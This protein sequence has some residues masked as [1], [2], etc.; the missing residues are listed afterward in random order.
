MEKKESSSKIL[1]NYNKNDYTSILGL[2]KYIHADAYKMIQSE[3]WTGT[4][5]GTFEF[6]FP[7]Y[8]KESTTFNEGVL[9]S[10]VLH[11]ESNWLDLSSQAGLLS[12]LIVLIVILSLLFLTL[13]KN[14]RSRS[15]LLCLSCILSIFCILFH[16]IVD[17]PG[18]K[19]GIILSGILLIGVTLKLDHSKDR[20]SKRYTIIIYQFLAVGIFSLGLILVHSQW[21]SS[22]SIVFSDTQTRINKIQNL[23]QLSIDS[24]RENDKI[25]KKNS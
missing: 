21:F 8:Q 10:K 20:A 13:F 4:G 25:V 1:N 6:I 16:G 18:Q 17:V 15:W 19:F 9:N 23:Y 2:R 11:P 7:F 5:L 24:A 14:R 22:S 3:P 12:T